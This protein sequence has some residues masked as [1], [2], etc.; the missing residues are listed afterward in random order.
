[1]SKKNKEEN[2][3]KKIQDIELDT[4]IL[5]ETEDYSAEVSADME[6][7]A[8][9]FDDNNNLSFG[10][11]LK[12]KIRR[13]WA[14]SIHTW[15]FKCFLIA[16]PLELLLEMLGR[17]SIFLGV[18]FMFTQPI[19]FAYNTSIVFFTLLF[20]LFLKKRVFGLV[21]ITALWLACGIINFCVLT[22][23]PSNYPLLH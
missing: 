21:T 14:Y 19:V 17:R 10:R 11:K 22:K 1:M 2:S 18:K 6:D 20:A 16:L 3:I 23:E 13:A 8:E 9:E 12:N 4:D 15:I 5:E 7:A